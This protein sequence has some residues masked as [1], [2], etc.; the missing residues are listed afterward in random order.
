MNKVSDTPTADK[1]QVHLVD[2]TDPDYDG[3]YVWGD[4]PDGSGGEWHT[5]TCPCALCYVARKD[6]IA[7]CEASRPLDPQESPDWVCE[8]DECQG[9]KDCPEVSTGQ[10]SMDL[11][12]KRQ[13]YPGFHQYVSTIKQKGK[14]LPALLTRSDGET[15]LYAGKINTIFGE[16]GMAKSW[17]ALKA[18][19]ESLEKGGRVLWWDLE[20]KPDTMYRRAKALGKLDLITSENVAFVRDSSILEPDED[21]NPNFALAAAVQWLVDGGIYS[22]VIIDAAESSGAPSDGS[23]VKEWNNEKI[24]PFKDSE[25]GGLI[26]D[27][28]PKRRQERPRGAIGSQYKLAKIDGA[29][30]GI[31]GKAWTKTQDGA[32]MLRLEK[33]R[34]GDVPG[35]VGAKIASVKGHYE[36]DRLTITIDPPNKDDDGGVDM[37][38]L[39]LAAIGSAGAE[40]VHSARALYSMV[41]GKAQAKQESL[42]TLLGD[43]LVSVSKHGQAKVHTITEAGE[44]VL[45]EEGQ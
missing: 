28:V 26:L 13:F 33:D 38:M 5:G 41:K 11:V 9:C 35:N 15:L 25:V 20:D 23:P 31:S 18:A 27:H 36:G 10:A 22:V 40:G 37:D 3:G 14:A 21:D 45:A 2:E 44:V 1:S 42:S 19:I 16:P 34:Q 43:G 12:D 29:A 4:N 8:G 7:R 24:Q 39:L 6:L 17:V 30:I 32:L